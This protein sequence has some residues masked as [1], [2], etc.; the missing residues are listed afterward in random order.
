MNIT[1]ACMGNL[2]LALTALFKKMGLSYVSPPPVSERTYEIGFAL[3]P[4]QVCLPFKVCM[5][6]YVEAIE[7]GADTIVMAGGNGPC[8]FGLYGVLQEKLLFE[9]GYRVN[10]MILDQDNV[11]KVFTELAAMAKISYA[12]IISS[13][14]FAWKVLRLSEKNGKLA[15]FYRA[16]TSGKKA[17]DKIENEIDGLLFKV[18]TNRQIEKLQRELAYYYS[19]NIKADID[20]RDVLKIGLLGEIYMLLDS[21]ANMNIERRLGYLNVWTDRTIYL[22]SWL[23]KLSFLDFFSKNSYRAQKRVALSYISSDV[24]GKGVQSI[25]SAIT[26]ARSGYD[27]LIHITPLSCMP[28]LV[29]SSILP[30]VCEDYRMPCLYLTFDGHTAAAAFVTRLEA[31]VDMLK[32]GGRTNGR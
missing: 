27:G 19:S 5:G 30:K 7:N 29:A 32:M 16:H 26:F 8:R 21:S 18:E 14:L 17:V 20:K 24:G 9:A 28:E 13:F 31:Y 23:L 22:S 15:R 6:N 3:S 11:F 4:E 2:N 1:S 10:M 12:G 25:A